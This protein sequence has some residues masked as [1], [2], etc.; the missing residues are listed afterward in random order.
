MSIPLLE[1]SAHGNQ[2]GL[3]DTILLILI[4]LVVLSLLV[5]IKI[6]FESG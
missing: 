6:N 1:P 4:A 3:D 2:F 5:I